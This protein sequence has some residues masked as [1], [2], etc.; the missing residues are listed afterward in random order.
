MIATNIILGAAVLA[1]CALGILSARLRRNLRECRE[2]L[3]DTTIL[4]ARLRRNL[5]EC[6]ES[7]SD[8]TILLE[9][10]RAF[11]HAARCSHRC[12]AMIDVRGSVISVYR[13]SGGYRIDLLRV[14]FD[15]DEPG[16]REYKL[17]FAEEAADKINE[18]P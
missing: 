17:V 9:D 8:T 14:P 12:R 6:R 18:R 16:D 5:R 3:S 15:P 11:R 13:E 4:S 1:A 10:A 2:S 7:L